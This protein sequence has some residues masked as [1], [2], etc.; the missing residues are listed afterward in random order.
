[1]ITQPARDAQWQNGVANPITWSKGVMDGIDGFDIEL[2]RLSTE[3]LVLVARD[4]PVSPS[5]LN[6]YLDNVPPGDDYFLLFLNSTPGTVYTTSQRFSILSSS[7]QGI[8][9]LP[10]IPNVP[11]I[12]ISGA[13]DPT[14]AWATTFPALKANSAIG[15]GLLNRKESVV[16]MSV[17]MATCIMAFIIILGQAL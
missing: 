14:K 7:A 10:P 15:L 17:A 11:T 8:Y 13:P 5:S 4:V 12:T 6:I 3:G 1:M 9:P 2:T 16:G